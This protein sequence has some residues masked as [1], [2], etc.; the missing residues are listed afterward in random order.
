MVHSADSGRLG[1]DLLRRCCS[2]GLKGGCTLCLS[3]KVP[4]SITVNIDMDFESLTSL[5]ARLHGRDT[6]LGN[7]SNVAP[8]CGAWVEDDSINRWCS[9]ET[10]T[11]TPVN[12]EIVAKVYT[13]GNYTG[14]L[15][16]R[17]KENK[18]FKLRTI[19]RT[20]CLSI[21]KQEPFVTD[22]LT[23]MSK[24]VHMVN[25]RTKGGPSEHLF[26]KGTSETAHPVLRVGSHVFASLQ[27]GEAKDS[28]IGD[29]VPDD[30][31]DNDEWRE[32]AAD[33]RLT[34]L[35]VRDH[36]GRL[37]P[38]GDVQSELAG[39]TVLVTFNLKSWRWDKAKPTG[40]AADVVSIVIL[41]R[42]AAVHP[43]VLPP[44]PTESRVV[45]MQPLGWIAPSPLLSAPNNVVLPTFPTT[46]DTAITGT[47]QYETDV[48]GD[49]WGGQPSLTQAAQLLPMLPAPLRADPAVWVGGEPRSVLFQQMAGLD[50][51]SRGNVQSGTLPGGTT[52]V[53]SAQA[54]G[55]RGISLNGG[56]IYPFA[57]DYLARK[58]NV[59]TT[60]QQPQVYT[61]P[62]DVREPSKDASSDG[63]GHRSEVSG[64][65]S[66]AASSN[67]NV[68]KLSGG[69]LFAWGDSDNEPN[70]GKSN[71][72]I[73]P[74]ALK[75][76]NECGNQKQVPPTELH[77]V[78]TVP[79]VPQVVT[80]DPTVTFT[81][82][83]GGI[84]PKADAPLTCDPRLLSQQF[85][86]GNDKGNGKN[87]AT[88]TDQEVNRTSARKRALPAK[89]AEGGPTKV[90]K[91]AKD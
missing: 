77:T 86:F 63:S 89:S 46:G 62:Y 91:I 43:R 78:G 9:A 47:T 36:T 10:G 80:C 30:E 18:M 79:P 74:V 85:T 48:E 81:F 35:D 23:A 73:P 12:L 5:R 2:T 27:P 49:V 34:R 67:V 29:I 6:Y 52:A 64:A 4:S 40:L 59:A 90:A 84:A 16:G 69:A 26:Q 44:W 33:C 14:L 88:A 7:N 32:V 83:E 19:R 51:I 55:V 28:R 70:S 37:I 75:Q 17:R 21:P 1:S 61:S 42:A 87:V 82:T 41:A 66:D 60:G 56:P 25:L 8:G 31:K 38:E 72:G 11:E 71:E 15:G 76:V 65:A 58:G 50:G 39:A 3:N 13:Y 45:T 24:L 20:L 68:K 22:Y 57:G 53:D 54:V